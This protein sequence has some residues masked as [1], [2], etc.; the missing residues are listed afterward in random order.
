MPP[1]PRPVP[2]FPGQR[3]FRVHVMRF[4]PGPGHSVF[5]F[6]LIAAVVAIVLLLV[7]FLM[8]RRPSSRPG[9]AKGVEGGA[10]PAGPLQIL[11]ERLA[12]G[13]IDADDYRARRELLA[14]H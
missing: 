11:D 10:S 3:V 8:S 9:T 13:E 6:L 14:S 7:A 12:R 2:P 1:F 4:G 5:W